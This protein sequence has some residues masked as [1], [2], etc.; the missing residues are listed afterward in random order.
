MKYAFV[1]NNVVDVVVDT[2]PIAMFGSGFG[3]L[4][5]EVPDDVERFWIRDPLTNTFSAPPP[6]PLT[7]SDFEG[8]FNSFAYGQAEAKRIAK[9]QAALALSPNAPSLPSSIADFLLILNGLEWE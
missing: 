2:D 3:S 7:V 1:V 4:F 6:P 9:F 8:A 5:V